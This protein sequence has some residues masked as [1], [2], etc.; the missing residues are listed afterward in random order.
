MTER[1]KERKRENERR[2]EESQRGE[3]NKNKW[4]G[5]K[6]K[7]KKEKN[8]RPTRKQGERDQVASRKERTLNIYKKKKKKGSDFEQKKQG[9][10]DCCGETKLFPKQTEIS[11]CFSSMVQKNVSSHLVM[12]PSSVLKSISW[13]ITRSCLSLEGLL[14]L[15]SRTHAKFPLCMHVPGVLWLFPKNDKHRKHWLGQLQVKQ[16]PPG[17]SQCISGDWGQ[18]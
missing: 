4:K 1:K 17:A 10:R 3:Q 16:S 15:S 14:C 18:V 2:G 9:L 5:G 7:V 8:E 12:M 6:E 11:S 13:I